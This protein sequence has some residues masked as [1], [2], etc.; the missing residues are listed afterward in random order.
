MK[1]KKV[2]IFVF[3]IILL[4]LFI[5]TY[6]ISVNDSSSYV[7][8]AEFNTS[9]ANINNTII[10][11]ERSIDNKIANYISTLPMNFEGSSDIDITLNALNNKWTISY[12]GVRIVTLTPST[13]GAWVTTTNLLG[14][15]NAQNM[16][17]TIQS[18]DASC[19]RPTSDSA[20]T[21]QLAFNVPD[22]STWP[23]TSDKEIVSITCSG[24][25]CTWRIFGSKLII[26][27]KTVL[28]YTANTPVAFTMASAVL[29]FN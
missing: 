13:N 21:P 1:N 12:I 26:A 24:D 23:K 2:H 14:S 5:N 4:F 25:V 22:N 15:F 11:L 18:T 17:F 9:I 27:R 16:T 29:D 10:S 3:L 8:K 7:T 28:N 6:S 20:T 19:Y